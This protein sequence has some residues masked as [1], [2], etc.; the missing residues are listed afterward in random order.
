MAVSAE[1]ENKTMERD[2]VE[3]PDSGAR[4]AA[5]TEQAPWWGENQR[6]CGWLKKEGEEM[7]TAHAPIASSL[8]NWM[9]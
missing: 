1:R 5:G 3:A 8:W 7:Q 9:G 6:G 2:S 4:D